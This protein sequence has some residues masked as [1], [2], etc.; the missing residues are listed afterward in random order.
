MIRRFAGLGLGE[1]PLS[2]VSAANTCTG[3]VQASSVREIMKP[4]GLLWTSIR[5]KYRARS[6][7]VSRITDKRYNAL[8]AETKEPE[9]IKRLLIDAAKPYVIPPP[10]SFAH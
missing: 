10:R 9:T 4:A 1:W 8:A 2:R 5:W 6:T 7:A 3:I